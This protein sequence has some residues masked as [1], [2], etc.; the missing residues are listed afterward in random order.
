M[1]RL[2]IIPLAVVAFALAPLGASPHA[3]DAHH[4]EKAAKAG[5]S[6]GAKGKQTRKPVAKPKKTSAHQGWLRTSPTG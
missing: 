4:P 3:D 6:T 1:K 2:M 5:K